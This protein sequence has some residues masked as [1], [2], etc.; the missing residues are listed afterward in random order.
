MHYFL[1]FQVRKRKRKH[2]SKEAEEGSTAQKEEEG[3]AALAPSK[4]GEEDST[5]WQGLE[6]PPS[7][8]GLHLCFWPIHQTSREEE[9]G[10]RLERSLHLPRSVPEP[11]PRPAT[12]AA[13]PWSR[14]VE[15][16][17]SCQLLLIP[18]GRESRFGCVVVVFVHPAY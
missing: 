2:H 14:T 3:K 7:S 15:V 8:S 10:G 11:E 18:S 5:T 12:H 9:L 16:L 1:Q 13:W 4:E 17:L 6:Q